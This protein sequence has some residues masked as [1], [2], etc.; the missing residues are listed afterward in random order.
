MANV[1]K[2]L[3][4]KGKEIIS[5]SPDTVIRDAICKM[6]E[7]SAG[8]ALVMDGNKLVGI[9]SERDIIRKVYL[10]DKCGKA[11]KV[12]EIMSTGLTTVKPDTT[13]ESCME[14]MTEKRIRHLPVLSGD[15]VVGVISIGD[16]VKFMVQEK[17]F[18]IKNLQSYISGPGM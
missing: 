14:M 12:S 7:K 15:Q 3:E 13:L 1:G 10:K 18:V 5:V 2:L 8:T 17:E 6:A 4:T 11:T 9:F 16:I